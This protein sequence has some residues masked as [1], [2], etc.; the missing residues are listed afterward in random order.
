MARRLMAALGAVALL[1][2]HAASTSAAATRHP[3]TQQTPYA[4]A[5]AAECPTDYDPVLD[6]AH[7]VAVVDNP[8]FPLPIDRTLVYRGIR[9][10]RSQVDRVTVTDRTK[11]V[12]GITATVVRDVAKHGRELLEKTSDLYAQDDLGNVWYLGEDTDAYLR[13]GTVD[14]SGSWQAGV[15]GA[16]AGII[17]EA[18]P[19]APDA[20]FEECR[21]GEAMDTAWVVSVGGSVTVPYGSVDDVLTTLE[22]TQLESDG[23]DRKLYAPGL[24]IVVEET[25]VG[26]DE[27]AEL[28]SVSG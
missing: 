6:P 22:Y 7:F 11:V 24:G 15:D 2:A 19:Q 18:H 16:K 21:S 28:V 23:V 27:Y 13:N 3:A 12:D 17:M 14:T 4:A 5:A 10:G 9:D 26:G 25:L 8:Y 20:Y 1:G